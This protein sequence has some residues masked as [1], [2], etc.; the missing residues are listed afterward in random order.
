MYLLW[1]VNILNFKMWYV[2]QLGGPLSPK[3]A[4]N[5]ITYCLHFKQHSIVPLI[6][7]YEHLVSKWTPAGTLLAHP[8]KWPLLSVQGSLEA[9]AQLTRSS[10]SPPNLLESQILVTDSQIST[11]IW[12]PPSKHLYLPETYLWYN[13]STPSI[14]GNIVWGVRSSQEGTFE[15]S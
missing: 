5:V 4:N 6:D 9:H 15:I 8:M 3:A 12:L 7:S 13:W 1:F 2:R 10:V 11:S 14:S